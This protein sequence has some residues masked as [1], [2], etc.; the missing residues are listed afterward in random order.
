MATDQLSSARL[1]MVPLTVADAAEMV[2]VLSGTALY[3]FTG[4]GPPGLDELRA[5]YAMLAAGRSPDGRA[6][7][8]DA[9]GRRPAV[10]GPGIRHRGRPGARRLAGRLRGRRHP[11]AHPP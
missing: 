10:A 7:G 6:A 3:D 8:R 5:R 4:G 9:L 1:R 11:G 2:A